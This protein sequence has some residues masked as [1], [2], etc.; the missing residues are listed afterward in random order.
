MADSSAIPFP[1]TWWAEIWLG[2]VGLPAQGG[3]W[4]GVGL[5]GRGGVGGGEA[6][7]EGGDWVGVGLQPD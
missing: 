4:V 2:V 7:G 6:P 3:A 5:Q 1:A